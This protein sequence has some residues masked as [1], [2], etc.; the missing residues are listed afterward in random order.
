LAE[1]KGALAMASQLICEKCSSLL[2]YWDYEKEI[3]VC[4]KCAHH[5]PIKDL[6]DQ[7]RCSI[8]LADMRL[9]K[10]PEYFYKRTYIKKIDLSA[11]P[12]DPFHGPFVNRIASI[13]SRIGRITDLEELD[14]TANIVK[15][16]PPGIG[17]CQA[18]RRLFLGSNFIRKVPPEIGK[19]KNLELLVLRNNEIK[20]LPN[21]IG[22]LTNLK[23]LN[24]EDNRLTSLP[25]SIMNLKNLEKLKL[26]GNTG[27]TSPPYVVAEQGLEAIKKWFAH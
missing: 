2:V 11:E 25:R 6:A 7:Y 16:I 4:E 5:F 22:C 13:S 12:G 14:L 21:E 19:L 18:L 27:L 10:F 24:L 23:T 3:F 8:H 26:S 20:T 9:T 17:N 1:S 15:V